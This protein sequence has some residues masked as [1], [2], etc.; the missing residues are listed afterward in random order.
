MKWNDNNGDDDDD[1]GGVGISQKYFI[2][3]FI[4]FNVLC[5]GTNAA[6]ATS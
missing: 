4:F 2:A 6:H 3:A 5:E 1:G